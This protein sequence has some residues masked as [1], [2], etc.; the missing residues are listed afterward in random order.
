MVSRRG[1]PGAPMIRPAQKVHLQVMVDMN[2]EIIGPRR[3]G[4]VVANINHDIAN[5][6]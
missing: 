3:G 2:P 6:R 4:N 1:R 5:P